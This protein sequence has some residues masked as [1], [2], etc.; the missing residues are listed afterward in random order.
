MDMILADNPFED[1]N[2]Q[3]ITYLAK[4]VTTAQLDITRKNL[5]TVFRYPNK[6]NLKIVNAMTLLR[7]SIKTGLSY[8]CTKYL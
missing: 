7:C 1:L 4:Y 5:I 2:V 8:K 3:R 6:V